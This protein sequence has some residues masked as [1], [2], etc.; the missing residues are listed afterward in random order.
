MLQN[1]RTWLHSQIVI[2]FQLY[3]LVSWD[4]TGLQLQGEMAH[5]AV[6]TKY[7]LEG[8]VPQGAVPDRPMSGL[9]MCGHALQHAKGSWHEGTAH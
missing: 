3:K 1:Q 9:H 4:F 5:G 2:I 8:N 7:K 6:L